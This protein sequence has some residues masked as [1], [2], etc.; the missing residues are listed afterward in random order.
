MV[1]YGMPLINALTLFGHC[2]G[3]LVPL[4]YVE[5][6]NVMPCYGFYTAFQGAPVKIYLL[7]ASQR[8]VNAEVFNIIQIVEW[9][10]NN[11]AKSLSPSKLVGSSWH[12]YH[13]PI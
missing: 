11:L 4:K 8:V 6:L 7:N 5:Q 2:F 1:S 12:V 10:W 3:A 13:L 9:R